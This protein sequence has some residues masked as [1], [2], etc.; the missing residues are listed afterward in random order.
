MH[1]PITQWVIQVGLCIRESLMKG[2]IK[3]SFE[4]KDATMHK[5]RAFRRANIKVL[6]HIEYIGEEMKQL[7]KA[8]KDK[9]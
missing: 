4:C 5:I 8:F 7:L 1:D 3:D 9:K 6:D 2:A